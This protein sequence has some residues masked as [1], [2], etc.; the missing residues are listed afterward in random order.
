M[1]EWQGD[2]A[3][4]DKADCDGWMHA[5]SL[6]ALCSP[7]F[8]YL[9]LAK[10]MLPVQVER[11]EVSACQGGCEGQEVGARHDDATVQF[12]CRVKSDG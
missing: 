6:D 11:H 1:W 10:L 8:V 7:P 12:G 5:L 2:W 9:A 4:K 3:V